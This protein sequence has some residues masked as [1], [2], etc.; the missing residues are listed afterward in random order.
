MAI[1]CL[2]QTR[3][4]RHFIIVIIFFLISDGTRAAVL[5]FGTEVETVFSIDDG[6]ISNPQ[7]SAIAVDSIQVIHFTLFSTIGLI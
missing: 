2:L 7:L 5:T 6:N 4:H 3:T 1:Q